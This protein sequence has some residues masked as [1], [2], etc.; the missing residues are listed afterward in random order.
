MG[1]EPKKNSILSHLK[2]LLFY[3]QAQ[4]LCIDASVDQ[5]WK[6]LK[7]FKSFKILRS[8]LKC[9]NLN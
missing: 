6:E 4:N 1:S 5:I 9:L 3:K 8:L 2:S 7:S